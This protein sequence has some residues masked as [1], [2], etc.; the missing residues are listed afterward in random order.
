MAAGT[1]PVWADP[2]WANTVWANTVWAR[3]TAA[4][5]VRPSVS[6]AFD[7]SDELTDDA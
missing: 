2:V 4:A 5:A 3:P 6:S 7:L 1:D